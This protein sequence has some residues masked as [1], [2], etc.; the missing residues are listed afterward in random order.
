[1]LH[2]F[3]K[4][5]SCIFTNFRIVF[6][7]CSM[8]HKVWYCRSANKYYPVLLAIKFL[9]FSIY[10]YHNSNLVPIICPHRMEILILLNVIFYSFPDEFK[11]LRLI[12]TLYRRYKL[13]LHFPRK[14]ITWRSMQLMLELTRG[15]NQLCFCFKEHSVKALIA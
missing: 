9:P 13:F 4:F 1:M 15:K 8:S 11:C 5:I 12:G 3:W 10:P 14:H 7:T 6:K 2:K